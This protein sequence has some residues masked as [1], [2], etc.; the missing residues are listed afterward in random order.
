MMARRP[1][2]GVANGFPAN[3]P[4]RLEI[5]ETFGD[6]KVVGHGYRGFVWLE[7]EPACGHRFLYDA[8]NLRATK[9]AREAGKVA[10][11]PRC[12]E[13]AGKVAANG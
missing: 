3:S 7:P 4:R 11:Y 9:R 8:R 5:G 13:C 10:N 12:K 2:S 6:L 1:E